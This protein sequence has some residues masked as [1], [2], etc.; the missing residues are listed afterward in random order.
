M[1]TIDHDILLVGYGPVGQTF[2]ALAGKLGCNVGVYERYPSLYALPRAG[3]IDHEIMRIFQSIGCAEAVEKTAVRSNTY[4]WR[5]AAGELLINFEWNADGVSGWPSDFLI[6]QPDV[7]DALDAAVRSTGRVTVNHGW[8]AVGVV[9]HPDHVQLTVRDVAGKSTGAAGETR[10]VTAKYLVACDGGNSFVRRFLGLEWQDLGFS[11]P[12]LV[13]DF[14]EKRS[15]SLPY[16]N[17]QICDPARPMCLFQLGKE[18]RRFS[19]MV[20]PGEEEWAKR[21][22]TAWSLVAPW[23][24][25]DDVELIRQATYIFE[26]KLLD[27]W[28]AG[29]V[30]FAG[31][32]AHVMPPFMGQGMCSGI[33][34]AANLAWKMQLVVS[35]RAPESLLDTYCAERKPH[36]ADYIRLSMEVGRISCTTDPAAAA[37]R[38]K[39]LLSGQKLPSPPMPALV[40]GL[41]MSTPTAGEASVVGQL[42]PQ[43]RV[44][45]NLLVKRADDFL[46]TGWQLICR[47]DLS[48]F[49][50]ARA[51][52]VI[53]RLGLQ[54]VH[55]GAGSEMEDVDGTYERYFE[56]NGLIAVIVRPD[57]YIHSAM[58]TPD[59]LEP[60]LLELAERL[61]CCRS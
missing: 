20:M 59:R 31:D 48:E 17:A 43:G 3:H 34:D 1:T 57:F 53:D 35:G 56:A 11:Q 7:E 12:W 46:G 21:T 32:A 18:H 27:R 4:E 14:K 55:F 25:E 44:R 19:Y 2:A 54:I 58:E 15:L 5:N 37:A 52:Q 9:Q 42:G 39:A 29:R 16:E 26:S 30:L 24:R 33:R 23:V 8:E 28:R 38:D 45:K 6:F 61:N 49:I 41:L 36:V 50:S 13:V 47:L 51:T 10:Q 22:E 40:D 60:N